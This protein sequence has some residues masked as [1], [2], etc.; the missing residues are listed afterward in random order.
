MQRRLNL[1]VSFQLFFAEQFFKLFDKD[2]SGTISLSELIDGLN[3]LMEGSDMD[4][5]KFLFDVYDVDGESFESLFQL[6]ESMF[7]CPEF[8]NK[9]VDQRLF[10]LSH[11]V[12]HCTM[13][14]DFFMF[15]HS[16]IM[17]YHI[18]IGSNIYQITICICKGFCQ[19]LSQSAIYHAKL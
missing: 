18:K 9:S 15:K 19:I 13:N 11:V 1:Q 17:N 5:L 12:A 8:Q 7:Y 16:S 10:R 2:R 14:S 6:D 4:K 3:M